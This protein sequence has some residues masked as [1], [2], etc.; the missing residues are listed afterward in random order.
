MRK[1]VKVR[2]KH[3]KTPK[4]KDDWSF[5]YNILEEED[6]VCPINVV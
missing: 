3:C 1:G 2:K 4:E 5:R 6:V